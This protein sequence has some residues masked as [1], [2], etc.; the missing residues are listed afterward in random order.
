MFLCKGLRDDLPELSGDFVMVVT[1]WKLD[2]SVE[3]KNEADWGLNPYV[4]VSFVLTLILKIHKTC[5][6]QCVFYS[7]FHTDSTKLNA[8]RSR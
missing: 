4:S 6:D 1:D 5:M 2:A 3:T 7:A 8:T